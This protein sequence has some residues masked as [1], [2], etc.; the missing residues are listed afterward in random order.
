MAGGTQDQAQRRA[1][2]LLGGRE[3]PRWKVPAKRDLY[4]QPTGPNSLD[5]RD[6]FSRPALRHGSL[7][8]F[9]TGSLIS[10]FL[11]GCTC[12]SGRAGLIRGQVFFLSTSGNENHYTH[13]DCAAIGINLVN[14]VHLLIPAAAL[15]Q[16]DTPLPLA[17]NMDQRAA[18]IGLYW[19]RNSTPF[20]VMAGAENARLSRQ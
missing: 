11:W 3:G 17:T 4:R 15:V 16:T 10:A 1:R 7:N 14:P 12:H 5:N 18:A 6:D 20:S 13:S 9:L 2:L 19:A 8:S